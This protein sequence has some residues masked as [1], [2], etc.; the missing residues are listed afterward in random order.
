MNF[1]NH[2]SSTKELI[3]DIVELFMLQVS[4]SQFEYIADIKFN[5]TTAETI[6]G[7]LEV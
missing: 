1:N 4:S 7:D 3:V 2:I 6:V 5:I